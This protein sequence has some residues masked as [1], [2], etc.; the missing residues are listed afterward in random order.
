[1][2]SSS[3]P[4]TALFKRFYL[5]IFRERKREGEEHRFIASHVNP[6]QE[7]N[8]QPWH[9]PCMGIKPASF[10][11]ARRSPAEPHPSGGP[12]SLRSP[13]CVENQKRPAG[14]QQLQPESST[15]KK[16]GRK[17]PQPAAEIAASRRLPPGA[18]VLFLVACFLED[19]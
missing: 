11:C 15:L 7:P 16:P 2:P 13:S 5:F 17:Y 10:R 6:I 19:L 4:L 9:M 14:A 18:L 3:A 12:N 1:M 8:L